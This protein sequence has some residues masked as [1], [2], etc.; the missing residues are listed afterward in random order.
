MQMLP[1]GETEV[2]EGE[3]EAGSRQGWVGE[4]QEEVEGLWEVDHKEE[5]NREEGSRAKVCAIR[6]S[7]ACITVRIDAILLM[8]A[9]TKSF[10][11]NIKAC[12]ISSTKTTSS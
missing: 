11:H 2:V 8:P 9:V 5:D 1:P 12:V 10:M 7:L 4:A 3:E 6:D